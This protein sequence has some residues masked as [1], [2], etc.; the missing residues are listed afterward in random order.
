ML[1][2]FFTLWLLLALF[3]CFKD[4]KIGA[5]IFLAYMILV[6]NIQIQ[7]GGHIFKENLFNT[8]FLVS[9][10]YYAHKNNYKTDF[11]PFIPFIVYF[12]VCFFSI[13]FQTHTPTAFMTNLLRINVMRTL[14]LP[15]V[16]WNVINITPSS[17]TLFRNTILISITIAIIYGLYLTTKD[18]V[19]PY[20]F[21]CMEI[22]GT[23]DHFDIDYFKNYYAAEGTGR[24]FGRIS[25]VF[26]HPMKFALFIGLSF[27]FLFN[28][29]EVIAKKVFVF[30]SFATALMA[31]FCGVRSVLAG[32][33]IAVIYYLIVCKNYKMIVLSALLIV[34]G[35]VIIQYFPDMGSYLGSITD[36]NNTNGDIG[37]SSFDMRMQQLE[38]AIYEMSK[39]PVWGLGYEWTSYYISKY[40]SHP[41][42]LC[43]ESL[44]YNIICN[45]GIVGIIIWMYLILSILKY[46][47]SVGRG[48]STILN[49]TLVFYLAFS[50]ITGENGYM[51]YYLI[52]YVIILASKKQKNQGKVM[53]ESLIC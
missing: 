29:R 12:A 30:L 3:F 2:L 42:C 25:S 52:F 48:H 5:S 18:G 23:D 31:F 32:L 33:G 43:F 24:L 40:G 34:V 7:L 50:F 22:F 28:F 8:A 9:Y 19:N 35:I 21:I 15:F 1:S 10:I 49:S 20:Q 47:K 36:L 14:I 51:Q 39:N 41:V 45:N 17:I 4:L 53:T 26:T 13:F 46:N 44:L 27:I 6:P 37:G 16:I 11:R 38:G